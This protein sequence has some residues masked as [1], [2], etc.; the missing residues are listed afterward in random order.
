METEIL[1]IT[2]P[3]GSPEPGFI[4]AAGGR[5]VFV[6]RLGTGALEVFANH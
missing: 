1:D 3:D 2:A 4:P 5:L 6:A